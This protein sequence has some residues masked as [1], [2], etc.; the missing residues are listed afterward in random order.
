VEWEKGTCWS[1]KAAISLKCVKI[2][3]CYYGGPMGSYQC[4]FNFFGSPPY[5]YFRFRFYATE[6]AVFALFL[7]VQP[8][9]RY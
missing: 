8:S 5:F 7:P 2:E 3:E 1:T 9:N 6:M 4:S